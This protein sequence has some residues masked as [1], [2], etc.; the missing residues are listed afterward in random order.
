MA[1]YPPITIPAPPVERTTGGLYAAANF[2]ELP[3]EG[4]QWENG[5][6]YE[7]E[8]CAEP[9]GWAV[10]CIDDEDRADKVPTLTL[11]VVSGTPFVAY[12]GIQ[13]AL[14]GHS[15]EEYER[16]ARNAL[17]LCE[18]K[19]VERAFWT[20]DLGNT[21]FLAAGVYD[22]NTNPDGVVILGPDAG[23]TPLSVVQGIAAL[24]QYLGDN[25]CGVGVLHAP[26]AVAPFA[27]ENTQI[28][29]SGNR[30]TTVLGTRWAFGAGYSVNTGPTGVEAADGS[31]WIYATGQVNILRSDIWLQPGALEQA[32]NRL[33]NDAELYAERA[34]VITTE[35]VKA[36]VRVRLDCDC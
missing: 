21:P 29:G 19:A 10:V 5:V 16:M 20:G 15:L 25:Y 2:P 24:E 3:G 36:A 31:A 13:C 9:G 30:M 27:A 11:P 26:R 4:N 8:T 14:V 28:V 7:N 32:F 1:V 23:V 6:Q 33:T 12:L 18:Q 22:V 17:D 35:C 34:F